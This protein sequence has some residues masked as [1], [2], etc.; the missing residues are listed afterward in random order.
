MGQSDCTSEWAILTGKKMDV[1]ATESC[2]E[3]CSIQLAG[4]KTNRWNY[5]KQASEVSDE[6][7]NEMSER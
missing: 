5:A 4:R 6:R 7:T 1:R 3:F 2:I